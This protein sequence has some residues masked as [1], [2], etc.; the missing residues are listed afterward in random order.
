MLLIP[1][2]HYEPWS[3]SLHFSQS[4]Q[5]FEIGHNQLSLTGACIPILEPEL[6]KCAAQDITAD[7]YLARITIYLM[8]ANW[9]NAAMD[10]RR[11]H[12]ERLRSYLVPSYLIAERSRRQGF[13]LVFGGIFR[14]TESGFL[15]GGSCTAH[16]SSSGPAT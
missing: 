16:P 7:G 2:A 5:A 4:V 12:D 10:A 3:S 8:A 9:Q 11:V 6:K 1:S 14:P 13:G 15:N